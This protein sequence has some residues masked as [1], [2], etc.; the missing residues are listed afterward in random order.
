MMSNTMFF[1]SIAITV[2]DHC[3][4]KGQR[5]KVRSADGVKKFERSWMASML[6]KLDKRSSFTA[7]DLPSFRRQETIFIIL[8][9]GFLALLLLLHTIFASYWGRPSR[10]LV[11]VL[12]AVFLINVFELVWLQGLTQELKPRTLKLLTGS[13]ICLSL[14]AAGFLTVLLDREDSPY[15]AVA[16]VA[17]LFAAFRLSLPAVVGVVGVATFLNFAS[18]AYYF[19]HHSPKDAGEYFEAGVNSLIFAI[20]GLLAWFL[21][22]QIREHENNLARNLL[23]LKQTR[24]KL[25]EEETLAAVGR[26][27]SSIAHEIRNPVAMISSSLAMA[28]QCQFDSAQRDEMCEIAAREAARLE[29]L[30][31]DFL[32]YA[33]PREPETTPSLVHDTLAYVAS[34]CRAHAGSKQVTI[35]VDAPDALEAELDPAQIQ[36]ALLNLL[37]NAIDAAPPGSTVRLK[38]D[39]DGFSEVK[40]WVTNRGPEIPEQVLPRIFEP[41]FTTKA[42]G[43]GLGLA[44]ARNIARAHGGDLLISSNQPDNVCFCLCLPAAKAAVAIMTTKD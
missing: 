44:I 31:T 16:V 5:A 4:E 1:S 43:T 3:A 39:W 11:L 30:T 29:K 38:S 12:G 10:T 7:S 40:I 19:H 37:M 33:R 20:V 23:D 24:A 14:A 9:V 22:K 35:E 42:R 32:S 6:E 13:S 25:L 26:L 41:F 28:R 2:Q 36:Q 34:V 27:S 8:N 15:F 18:I 17:V 21:L